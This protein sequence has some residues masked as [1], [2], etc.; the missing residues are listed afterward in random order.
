MTA[1]LIKTAR[2]LEIPQV[3]L[4][5]ILFPAAFPPR[6]RQDFSAGG[7]WRVTGDGWRVAGGG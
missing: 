4:E 2:G 3:E 6:L 7:G 1:K 5:Q